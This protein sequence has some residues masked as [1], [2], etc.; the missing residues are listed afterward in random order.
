MELD[1]RLIAVTSIATLATFL[2][3]NLQSCEKLSKDFPATPLSMCQST[4]YSGSKQSV[5]SLFIYLF[6]SPDE[7]RDAPSNVLHFSQ[8]HINAT[9]VS[10][11][12]NRTVQTLFTRRVTHIQQLQCHD[13]CSEISQVK[14]ILNATRNECKVSETINV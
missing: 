7:S 13:D 4:L 2:A 11:R 8:M 12:G 10:E 9:A 1:A 5:P 14:T 6:F 3:E